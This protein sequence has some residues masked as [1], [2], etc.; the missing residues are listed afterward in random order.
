MEIVPCRQ[1]ARTHSH[2]AGAQS[3][4]RVRF[5]GVQTEVQSASDGFYRDAMRVLREAKIGFL[6]GGAYALA[7][8]TGVIR[9]TKDFDLFL[10]ERDI[11]TALRAF[12]SAGYKAMLTFPHWLAKVHYSDAFIDLIFRA[13]NGLC[14]VD[15]AWF[16]QQREATLLGETVALVPPERMIWQKAYIQERERFDGADIAHLLRSCAE[17]LK[18]E[19]LLRLFGPDWRIFYA[20]LIVFGFIY[21]GERARIPKA[22][23]EELASR[24]EADL[25]AGAVESRMCHGTLLSRAQYLPDIDLWDYADARLAERSRMTTEHIRLWT[26]A[27]EK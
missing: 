26:S 3:P 11:A 13:G 24:L 4:A 25:E 5:K 16:A 21:P 23:M 9:D 1:V 18:W 15:D 27:I 12:E 2:A 22:I 17:T 14:D 19:E 10:R 8:Y 6:I 7:R 20:H